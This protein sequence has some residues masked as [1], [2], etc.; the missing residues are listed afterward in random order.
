MPT[1][2]QLNAYRIFRSAYWH[3]KPPLREPESCEA[4]QSTTAGKLQAH[5]DDYSKP[6]EVRW[7]CRSCH[8]RHHAAERKA[9]GLPMRN[10]KKRRAA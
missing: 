8:Q 9:A 3:G 10:R 4:C 7:L 6:L 5:H 1:P 2:E